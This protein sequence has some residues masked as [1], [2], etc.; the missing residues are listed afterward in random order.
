[1]GYTRSSVWEGG[2]PTGVLHNALSVGCLL[3][4]CVATGLCEDASCESQPYSWC[5]LANFVVDGTPV[6]WAIAIEAA[7][8]AQHPDLPFSMTIECSIPTL[9]VDPTGD[10]HQTEQLRNVYRNAW[11]ERSKRR[12]GLKGWPPTFCIDIL[13]LMARQ[14]QCDLAYNQT[15]VVVR[16]FPADEV[17]FR[18]YRVN[19]GHRPWDT[20][21]LEGMYRTFGDV[22][23]I[24][25]YVVATSND[26]WTFLVLGTLTNHV[27]ATAEGGAGVFPLHELKGL[28]PSE[29]ALSGVQTYGPPRQNHNS[30]AGPGDKLKSQ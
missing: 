10:A 20:Q 17:E 29:S 8:H 28:Y 22:E 1:M 12:A 5:R 25:G 18:A 14:F 24:R 16:L 7:M 3:L 30:S 19:K 15:S 4:L 6:E 27:R 26:P 11:A 13:R 2:T 23:P 9:T 21:V